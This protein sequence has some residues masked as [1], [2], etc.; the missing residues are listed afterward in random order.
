MKKRQR[1]EFQ[2]I[3]FRSETRAV[4]FAGL[5]PPIDKIVEIILFFRNKK[6]F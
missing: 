4:Q 1:L 2:L 5:A 3:F 6:I